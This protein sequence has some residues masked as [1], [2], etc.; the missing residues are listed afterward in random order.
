MLEPI[1]VNKKPKRTVERIKKREKKF[2]AFSNEG[3]N[4]FISPSSKIAP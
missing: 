2:W 4:V 3:A 1:V